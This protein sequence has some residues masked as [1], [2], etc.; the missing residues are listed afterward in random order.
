VLTLTARRGP[1][2]IR[3]EGQISRARRLH[4]GH[5][6]LTVTATAAGRRSTTGRPLRFTIVR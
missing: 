4:L 5:Y 2:Q 1:N 3:F 6:T